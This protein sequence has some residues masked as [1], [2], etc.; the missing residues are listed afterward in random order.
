MKAWLTPAKGCNIALIM[1]LQDTAGHRRRSRSQTRPGCITAC[2]A[3]RTVCAMSEQR[4]LAS[5]FSQQSS[6]RV[7]CGWP[8][9][10]RQTSKVTHLHWPK[11]PMGSS[12]LCTTCNTQ[13]VAQSRAPVASICGNVPLAQFTLH[14][15]VCTQEIPPGFLT[16]KLMVSCVKR[17]VAMFDAAQVHRSK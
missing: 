15:C 12:S 10:K 16:L 11:Y 3:M 6:S 5:S 9:C 2:S 17:N 14:M 13:H 8:T 7:A 4:K 1:R